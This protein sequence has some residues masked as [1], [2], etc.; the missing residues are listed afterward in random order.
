MNE[1]YDFLKNKTSVN[2]VAT[3]NGAKLSNK[4]F[5]DPVLFNN[6]IYVITDKE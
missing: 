6:K 1:A 5:C 2:F 3:I 4:P